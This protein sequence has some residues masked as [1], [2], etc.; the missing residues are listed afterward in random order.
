MR[1]NKNI[2]KSLLF[3]LL[4]SYS[5]FAQKKTSDFWKDVR[6]GGGLGLNFGNGFFSATIA[7]SAIYEINDKFAFGLGLNASFNNQKKVAKSTILGG[8]IIGL[9]SI[10]RSLQLS[11]EIEQLNVNTTYNYNLDLENTNYWT[12]SLFLGAGYRQDS[13]T[14]GLRYNILHDENKSIYLD[15]LVPF[16][17][18]YF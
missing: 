11:A 4:I 1:I 6:Y 5:I 18:F 3:F 8:S 17:R 12:P 9:Y 10:L 16:I 7:P 2:N 15:A 13:V 14:F